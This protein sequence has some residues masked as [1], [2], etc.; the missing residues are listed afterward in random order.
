M[1]ELEKRS[2]AGL[3]ECVRFFYDDVADDPKVRRAGSVLWWLSWPM[4]LR[5]SAEFRRSRCDVAWGVN[6]KARL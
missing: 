1:N 5:L 6:L 2:P 3:R 4:R